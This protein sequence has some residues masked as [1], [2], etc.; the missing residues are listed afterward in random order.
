MV[1][2]LIHIIGTLAGGMNSL[3]PPV[4]WSGIFNLTTVDA[5]ELTLSLYAVNNVYADPNMRIFLS[6]IENFEYIADLPIREVECVAAS[7]MNGA[8]QVVHSS[9]EIHLR[10]CALLTF[11]Y[12]PRTTFTIRACGT[13]SLIIFMEHNPL[14]FAARLTDKNNTVVAT[15]WETKY[16][17]DHHD[18]TVA[19]HDHETADHDHEMFLHDHAIVEHGHVDTQKSFSLSILSLCLSCT[20][21][22]AF[23]IIITLRIRDPSRFRKYLLSTENLPPQHSTTNDEPL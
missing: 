7:T 2:T 22:T 19:L 21:F 1:Y 20:T 17:Y 12:E 15:S 8:C 13:T 23:M 5:C 3:L 6:P 4:E 14:E 10:T 18:Y 11:D 9:N 16:T